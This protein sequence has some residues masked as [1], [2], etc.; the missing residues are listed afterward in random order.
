MSATSP[1]QAMS[2]LRLILLV[3]LLGGLLSV[4][5]FTVYEL[6]SRP[7]TS[8]RVAGDL[9]HTSRSDLEAAVAE[10]ITTS[11]Y[12]VDVEAI[13][14]AALALPWVKDTSVR[15]A[16]PDSLHLAVLERKPLARWP[17]GGLVEISGE[18]FF[19]KSTEAFPDLP[20]LRG[21]SGS[22]S[23]VLEKF[24]ALQAWLRP[25]GWQVTHLSL[26][27]RGAWQARLDDGVVLI[28][29]QEHHQEAVARLVQTFGTVLAARRRARSSGPQIHQ[30][31][32]D[33]LEI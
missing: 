16:W 30:W 10:H 29:G 27:P 8:V 31:I 15:R 22:Q 24:W 11:L 17:G 7:I 12:R 5:G 1:Q 4:A 33:T 18:V 26:N 6:H 2:R 25:V 13:R 20:M 21:P 32:R 3:L 28:L 19:P 14:E 9:W 23:Q